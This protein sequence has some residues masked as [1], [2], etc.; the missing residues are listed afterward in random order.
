MTS[1]LASPREHPEF[2][3]VPVILLHI[4]TGPGPEAT[5]LCAPI[6]PAII[7]PGAPSPVVLCQGCWQA[8]RRLP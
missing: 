7:T 3:G 1:L 6:V 5:A 4:R 8:A 2:T